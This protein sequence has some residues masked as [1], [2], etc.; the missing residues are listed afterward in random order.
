MNRLEKKQT[1]K[2]DLLNLE[3]E[4]MSAQA[5]ENV[6]GAS[7]CRCLNASFDDATVITTR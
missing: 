7:G 6:L 4:K 1:V 2:I 5:M 3:K